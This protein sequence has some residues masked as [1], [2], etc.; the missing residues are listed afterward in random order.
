MDMFIQLYNTDSEED[1]FINKNDV[2]IIGVKDNVASIVMHNMS[3]SV[4][5]L[6]YDDRLHFIRAVEGLIYNVPNVVITF[7]N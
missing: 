3:M 1:I 5:F 2:E 6:S 7:Q 4:K